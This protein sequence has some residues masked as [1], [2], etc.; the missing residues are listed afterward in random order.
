DNSSNDG[1]L[2]CNVYSKSV[3]CLL[4]EMKNKIGTGGCDPTVQAEASY[5]KYYTQKKNGEML[6]WCNWLSFLLCLAR[7]WV[8]I[9]EAVYVEKPIIDPLTDFISLI[10]TNNRSHRASGMAF[11][12]LA[13]GTKN[14]KLKGEV[15]K[16]KHDI[17]K[18]KLQTRVNTNE[19][20][21]SL[22]EDISQS[23]ACLE[24]PVT[25]E[26][27]RSTKGTSSNL[28]PIK[29]LSNKKYSVSIS[30]S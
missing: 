23:S 5:A 10:S 18:I 17:E 16:L 12:S 1:V 3:L 4:V 19:Q 8:C 29:D 22:I 14:A 25:L 13:L 11:Q 7:P 2:E 27:Q 21:A 6:Q 24:S 9:L 15:A 30:L 20:D 26:A 28:L